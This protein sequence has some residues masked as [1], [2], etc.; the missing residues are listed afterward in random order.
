[1]A[2][3]LPAS[4]FV[5]A[6]TLA[7]AGVLLFISWM[8]HRNLTALAMWGA[9][10]TMGAL[11]TF[12]IAERARI[13]DILS[14]FAANSILAGAY[15]M[16][17]TGARK[18]EG[19]KPL[20]VAAMSGLAAWLIACAI[21][22]FYATPTARAVLM[23]AIGIIYTLLTVYE[24]WRVRSDR[25][26]YR[27][28]VIILLTLHAAALPTRIPLVASLTG[29]KPA[30]A[31]LLT[32]VLF[33]SILLSMGG[34][35]LFAMLVKERL[36]GAYQ[37]AASV[38]AL[39]GVANRRAFLHQGGRLVQR[40]SI[41]RWPI[42]LLLF[43]LDRF[44]AIND[45]FGHA[46][47]DAVLM[48]FCN[49]AVEQLRPTDLFARIGGEEFACLLPDMTPKD[50]WSV[51]ERIRKAFAARVQHSGDQTISATVSVGVALAVA[52]R[53]DLP[54]LLVSAD[55]ALYRAKKEGRNR[56]AAE[57]CIGIETLEPLAA[58]SSI[59]Q[60]QSVLTKG[61]ATAQARSDRPPSAR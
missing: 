15:G 53:S 43:D 19:R 12:L 47:G 57:D 7:V 38:D 18:F 39:T 23:T 56:V 40:A 33:E 37:K 44:K 27:W 29:A 2:L 1:M 31:S 36:S 35:Y 26:L 3:D 21:P 25:L 49:L 9:A 55:R 14:I 46:A 60:L 5:S 51:A 20:V 48:D 34:A 11:A 45:A 6:F 32:F 41:E 8:Q 24:L 10:F 30:Q 17:W 61:R 50:A 28:P 13:P 52:D 42:A 54:S 22:V 58:A 16:M 4:L 59:A